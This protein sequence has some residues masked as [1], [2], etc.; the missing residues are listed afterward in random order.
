M[1]SYLWS[2]SPISRVESTNDA[3]AR[4]LPE[5]LLVSS[6]ARPR[7]SE[8]FYEYVKDNSPNTL[9][10]TVNKGS[11]SIWYE[12]AASWLYKTAGVSPICRID[13]VEVTTTAANEEPPIDTTLTPT[14]SST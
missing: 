11:T 13:E 4:P 8:T 1:G 3:D 6:G 14:T 10:V 2:E 5:Y 7:Q 9:L 12:K